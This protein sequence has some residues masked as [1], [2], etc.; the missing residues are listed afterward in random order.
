MKLAYLSEFLS[1]DPAFRLFLFVISFV[2]A[3]YQYIPY[4]RPGHFSVP[5]TRYPATVSNLQCGVRRPS[6]AAAELFVRPEIT[7]STCYY[8]PSR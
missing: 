8:I 7:I 2:P 3:R 6:S 4:R 1:P 5:E